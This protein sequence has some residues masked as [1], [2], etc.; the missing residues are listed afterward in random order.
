MSQVCFDI[1]LHPAPVP[2]VSVASPIPILLQPTAGVFAQDSH[3]VEQVNASSEPLG[4]ITSLGKRCHQSIS[5]LPPDDMK[6]LNS[7]DWEN[8]VPQFDYD[9]DSDMTGCLPVLP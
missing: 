4:Q 3:G 2:E 9:V 6:K 8:M 7:E 5:V 1:M